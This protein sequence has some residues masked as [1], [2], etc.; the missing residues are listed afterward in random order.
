MFTPS[1]EK[2]PEQFARVQQQFKEWSHLDQLYATVELTRTFQ[3]SYRHFLSQLYQG[4]IQNENNDMFNHTVDDANAPGRD[5]SMECL[6]N[7]H[8]FLYFR[9]CYLSL[10][11]FIR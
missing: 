2:F 3:L 5:K 7:N 10:I 11:K 6:L 4:N 8:I 9:Y 1:S